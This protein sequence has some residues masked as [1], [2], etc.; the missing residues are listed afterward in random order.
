MASAVQDFTALPFTST[1]QA[2]HWLVSQPTCV[3]VSPSFSRMNS[4][5]SVRPS[6]SP[7]TATP[8]TF[9]EIAGIWVLPIW[10]PA[11]RFFS[12]PAAMRG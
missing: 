1:T 8:F 9:M 3:P 11:G 6:T 12:N 2:P 4:T 5:S 10:T 7:Q